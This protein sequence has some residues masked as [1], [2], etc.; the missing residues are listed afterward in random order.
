MYRHNPQAAKVVELV[1][2][3]AIG[4]LRVVRSAFSFSLGDPENVRLAADLDGGALMDVGCYCVSGSRLLAGEPEIVF[5]QQVVGASGV[6]V[7]FAATMRFPGDV[8]AHFDCG[9]VLSDR[10]ELEVVGENGSLFLDDP[11]H[12][13]TPVIE[14]RRD[15][16]VEEIVLW[17]VDSYRLE[18]ENLSAAIEGRADLLLGRDDAVGQARVDRGALP[19]GGG[20]RAGR[21]RLTRS[22]GTPV[23]SRRYAGCMDIGRLVCPCL[24]PERCAACGAG[25]EILCVDCRQRLLVLRGTLR[26][27][28]LPD[29]VAGRAVRGV[30]GAAPFVRLG[31]R[32]G[33]VRGPG[34]E[35]VVA[36]KERGLRTIA[37]LAAD[38]VA[39]TVPR[40]RVSALTFVPRDGDR[41]GWRGVNHAEELARALG[42]RWALP[43]ERLLVR[44]R[45]ARPQRG[46]SKVERRANIRSAFRAAEP[47]PPTRRAR[48]R[49]LHDGGDGL[50]R[51]PR[52]HGRRRPRRPRRHLRPRGAVAIGCGYPTRRLR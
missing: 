15:E 39:A 23:R 43:V 33:R 17:P 14:L 2:D 30:R 7:L 24:L 16:G 32:R 8:F 22:R 42:S 31:A 19:L 45:T 29:R 47:S 41:V 1:R 12:A 36:W 6:D 34:R 26:P 52:A 40:P 20:R 48:R 25:E 18:L 13:R 35:L 49:C 3:G 28:R 4:K 27:V 50:R 21:A 38:I 11:W 46:L 5:G 9:F 51:G 44:S 37:G 10:D